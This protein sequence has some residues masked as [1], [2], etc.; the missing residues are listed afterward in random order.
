MKKNLA[1]GYDVYGRKADGTKG[2]L[3]A[4]ERNRSR[5]NLGV[6]GNKYSAFDTALGNIKNQEDMAEMINELNNAYQGNANYDY[7]KNKG[8]DISKF[9]KGSIANL[10]DLANIENKNR[11]WEAAQV[12][13]EQQYHLDVRMYLRGI[14]DKIVLGKKS[15]EI[16]EDGTNVPNEE[17]TFK[18]D[19]QEFKTEID[20]LGNPHQYV[21]NA[22]GE[23]VEATNDNET[24]ESK[25]TLSKITT[26]ITSIPLLG[27]AIGKISGLM[28][29]IKEKLFGS[30]DGKKKGFLSGILDMLSGKEGSPLGFIG[31]LLAGTKAGQFVSKALSGVTLKSVITGLLTD[32]GIAA[33]LGGIFSGKLDNLASDVTNGAYGHDQIG[34]KDDIRIDPESGEVLTQNEN[35]QWVRSDGSAVNNPE[36]R[37]S[38]TD[39]L[40]SYAI[41]GT[42]RQVVTGRKT[43]VGAL[44]KKTTLGKG[45]TKLGN[46]SFVQNFKSSSRKM[47]SVMEWTKRNPKANKEALEKGAAK[48]LSGNVDDALVKLAKFAKKFPFV[49][50]R[51]SGAI[52]K[53]IPD[54]SEKMGVSLAKSGAKAA[55]WAAKAIPII[56]IGMA[57]VDFT[58]GWQD[59]NATLGI[60]GT[61]S[62]GQ[63]ALCGVLR[64][65][66][67]LIPFVGPLIPDK[68]VIDILAKYIG[69]VFGMKPEELLK[70]QDEAQA[71]VDKYNAENGTN[72]TV[73]DYNKQV[74]G[75][76]TWT[77]KIGNWGKTLKERTKSFVS[78]SKEQGISKA[79]KESG[80]GETLAAPIKKVDDLTGIISLMNLARKG[81]LKEF[82]T[83]K[84]DTEGENGVESVVHQIP[85]FLTKVAMLPMAVTGFVFKPITKKIN[86]I[87]DKAKNMV[88]AVI[89]AEAEGEESIKGEGGLSDF[90]TPPSSLGDD[91]FGLMGKGFIYGA[92][93]MA[94]PIMIGKRIFKGI[95]KVIGDIVDKTKSTVTT[96]V[97]EIG[98]IGSMMLKGDITGLFD[99][100]NTKAA[101]NSND[102]GN[103]GTGLVLA[104]SGAAR[105]LAVIPT[106][107]SWVV[108]KIG[109]GIGNMINNGKDDIEQFS[110]SIQKISSISK[111][112]SG[113][114]DK[115]L[116]INNIE[117]KPKTNGVIAMALNTVFKFAKPFYTI[118]SAVKALIN[119]L[120]EL[121]DDLKEKVKEKIDNSWLGKGYNKIKNWI[122]GGEEESGSGSGFVSQRDSRYAGKSFASSTFGEKGCGPAV[123]SMAASAMG[124]NL[125]VGDAIRASRGYQNSGGT[126]LDYFGKVLGSK[127]I[128]TELIS[129]GSSGDLY[130]RIASGNKVILLGRDP[131]NT[132]K[133]NSPFGP[134]NHY[135]LAT[136]LDGAGNIR[137][138]DP[139]L[140]GTRSYSPAILKSATYG[141]SGGGSQ[142]DTKTAQQVWAYFKS[143]GYS[144]AAIAGIMGNLYQESGV[145]PTA[146][147]GNGRGPAAG[148]AQWENYN[149]KSSRWKTL[150]DRAKKAGKPWTDLATQLDFMNDEINSNDIK[151]RMAGKIAPGNLA[152]AGA[153]PMTLEQFKSTKD[154]N[155]AMRVFEG[156]FERAG[157]P[158]WSNREKAAEAYYKLYEDKN[159]TWTGDSSSSDSSES[160]GSSSTNFSTILQ[161]A[162]N[163]GS[164]FSNA[165]SKLFNPS[166]DSS[167]DSSS[168]ES[169]TGN[170]GNAKGAAAAATA[171]ENELGYKERPGNITKFGKWSGCDGQPWCAAFTTWAISQAFDGKKSSAVKA[172]YGCDNV[173]YTPTLT[174][175]FKKNN[176]WYQTPEV[177]DEVMYGKPG[178]YHVGLVTSVDK[179][180]KTFVSV[181]GNTNDQVSKKQ[182]SSYKDGNV[183]GFG[184]PDY[185]KATNT[186][187]K[188]DKSNSVPTLS[189][190]ENFSATGSSID[191][192]LRMKSGA[193]SGLKS[194]SG[195][196]SK[197]KAT[198][199]K[200]ASK[201][202]SSGSITSQT[203]KML[204]QLSRNAQ[205]SASNGSVSTDLVNKLLEAITALLSTIA[206]NTAPIE[207]IYQALT[208]YTS[209]A[210]TTKHTEGEKVSTDQSEV[211]QNFTA[212]VGVLAELAKG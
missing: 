43:G 84:P 180:K 38:G 152:K 115:I 122:K 184:R 186:V 155:Q 145:D 173:N 66:K 59:A 167:S 3:T 17:G 175:C 98:N 132:S 118:V 178:P 133:A 65:I 22:Q 39:S 142:Y 210:T 143:K 85:V 105:T 46:S 54:L 56:T 114:V 194:I 23:W 82:I 35:G 6:F 139:E 183:I 164:I 207:K 81:E 99:I 47:Q 94:L 185:S 201:V 179:K 190:N 200:K 177:G 77:E 141:I 26:A 96:G 192:L 55:S 154:V 67:N 148:I 5:Q 128:S 91:D 204:G 92:K 100:T 58:T 64:V 146:I 121:L 78:N 51:L 53:A 13:E 18:E 125:S 34:S 90:L 63:K 135:V 93:I 157:S 120:G 130:N 73:G 28:G 116:D 4:V 37:K 7:F 198:T 191:A 80:L 103:L 52:T 86:E 49:G 189:G 88:S 113:V 196:G 149:T 9:S 212:L 166:D 156:A 10:K 199:Y 95:G 117:F 174:N 25:K 158:M 172:L 159:Y 109:D 169:T 72:L 182:H 170:I 187:S 126:S 27:G 188:T 41:K 68:L 20:A 153:K 76:Y 111:S 102:M 134:N 171:A 136:G 127:G 33:L 108:H 101:D 106:A 83:Y 205:R 206:D 14:F 202:A 150:S 176:A 208:S 61:P 160:N 181:E 203:T 50:E 97:S 57:I 40:S 29:G 16:T 12:A 60:L 89:K 30:E 168:D 137:I 129:G 147:Q 112:D 31:N 69:P 161:A 193:G 21:K 48:A 162:S 45:I 131:M 140:N 1:H 19:K 15:S 110:S 144:P 79:F 36:V 87:I 197:K 124:R 75:N 209:N 8:V 195:A 62:T 119:P 32:V 165:F 123:A 107:I 151:Q 71:E 11:D 42:A 24:K 2:V 44:L 104:T 74:L 70:Q 211:D 163:V 138:N